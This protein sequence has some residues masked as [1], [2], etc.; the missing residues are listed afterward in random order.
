MVRWMRDFRRLRPG[1]RKGEP[2]EHLGTLK[3]FHT[4]IAN[5]TNLAPMGPAALARRGRGLP[6]HGRGKSTLE[7][8][9]ARG[10]FNTPQ[11]TRPIIEN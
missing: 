7:I 1:V 6:S 2:W 9:V 10:G 5:E 11:R 8:R 4:L 3:G